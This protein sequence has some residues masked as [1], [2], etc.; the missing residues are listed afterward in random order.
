M[1]ARPALAREMEA[2]GAHVRAWRKI[3]LLTAAMVAER[4]RISRDTLR[5]I[6]NGQSVSSENLLAVLQVSGVRQSGVR[7]PVSVSLRT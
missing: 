6:E 4:A 5:A 1:T 3:H 7:L 2:L